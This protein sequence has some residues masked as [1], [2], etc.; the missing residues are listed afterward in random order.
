MSF[1]IEQYRPEHSRRGKKLYLILKPYIKDGMRILDAGCSYAPVSHYIYSDFPKCQVFGFDNNGKVIRELK[2]R[3]SRFR[4]ERI[5]FKQGDDLKDYVI[6]A[7]EIVIHTGVNADWSNIWMVHKW[8][9]DSGREPQYVLLE[10]GRRDGYEICMKVYNRVVV[11]YIEHGFKL[12]DSGQIDH[13][14]AGEC[15][16]DR[17]YSLLGKS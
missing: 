2:N 16:R 4:W 6:T 10:T 11:Y 5:D 8:L 17:R 3:Y 7:P 15:L 14:F 1:S 9:M 12:L 13:D